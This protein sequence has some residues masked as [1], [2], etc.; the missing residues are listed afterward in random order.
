MKKSLK[1]F[2]NYKLSNSKLIFGGDGDGDDG[3]STEKK[4]LKVPGH[5]SS[6]GDADGN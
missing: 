1:D 6:G 5:G 3:G 2:Q 4:K